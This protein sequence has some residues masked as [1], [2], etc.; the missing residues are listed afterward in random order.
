M[1][2]AGRFR[3]GTW[4]GLRPLNAGGRREREGRREAGATIGMVSTRLDWA[5]L[6]AVMATGI[7]AGCGSSGARTST[8]VPARSRP[9]TTQAAPASPVPPAGGTSPDAIPTPGP[10]GL[11][12]S[13]EAVGVIRAWSDALRRGDV[14]AAARYFALPSV[15]INGPDAAG[16]AVISPIDT[17]AEAEVAN[18]S[19]PCGAKFLSADQRGRYVNALFRLTNRAGLGGSVG[20]GSGEGQTARTNFVIRHGRIEEWIRAPDD[21]GDNGGGGA[22]APSVPATSGGSAPTV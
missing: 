20:C 14:R 1:S 10:T 12:A 13:R 18:A 17:L 6:I 4:S 11:L 15:M 19:L 21:P 9:S 8:H 16:Q 5:P 3:P 7:L 2:A 22:P